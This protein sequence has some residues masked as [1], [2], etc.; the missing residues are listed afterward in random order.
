MSKYILPV[1]VFGTAFGCAVL[2][3]NYVSGGACPS[4]VKIHGKTVIVTGANTGIGKETARELARRGGRI[5]MGCRDMEKCEAA[6]REIR[7]QTLN[8]N[9]FAKHIDLA[10]IKSIQAFVDNI[11]Q[12]EEHVHVLINNAG[13]MRCPEGKTENGFDMQFGVNYLGPFLLTNLLLDKLKASAPSR[14]VNLASV[15]HVSGELD[16]DDLNWERRTFDT[17]KAY[18]Q[19]KLAV[20][21]FTR[22]LSKRLEG[23]GV[24]VNA[25][26][27]G[28]VAT[29]LGRHTGLHQS[30]LSSTVLSP[31]FYLFVKSPTLGAQ[32]SV[33]LAVA[34]ELEGVSGRYFD[35]MTEKDPAPQALDEKMAERLWNASEALL[36]LRSLQAAPRTA[37]KDGAS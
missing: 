1:S 37:M 10:S 19:S 23:A 21:L 16:F 36:G 31:F 7:G 29:D 20:V 28:I 3:K 32:S 5:I 30:Q 22:E 14:I 12:E 8:K 4:K 27:P 15:A 17:R 6:A 35:V 11:K 9:V 2:L 18:S 34:K 25:L 24:T 33:Y 26:H 13:V